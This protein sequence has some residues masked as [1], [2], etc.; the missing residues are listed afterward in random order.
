[1]TALIDR[2]PVRP[3]VVYLGLFLLVFAVV[4]GAAWIGGD[5]TASSLLAFDFL[6]AMWAVFPLALIHHLDRVSHRIA[7]SGRSVTSMTRKRAGS[8]P[9][10]DD[11][12]VPAA[13]VGLVGGAFLD[14]LSHQSRPVPADTLVGR[15]EGG[16][17]DSLHFQP[18]WASCSITRSANWSSGA[19]LRPGGEISTSST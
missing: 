16:W 4:A 13:I 11:A 8:T 17:D 3:S 7:S 2:V 18:C 10:D 19:G 14:H 1:M 15:A 6:S 9:P 5:P 12:G